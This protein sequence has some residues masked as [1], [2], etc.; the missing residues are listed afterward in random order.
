MW[1]YTNHLG[2]F[3][4]KVAFKKSESPVSVL[5]D[6]P[7][8]S[9]AKSLKVYLSVIRY[10]GIGTIYS[11][12]SV[13]FIAVACV[14]WQ[15]LLVVYIQCYFPLLGIKLC[16][17]F[18]VIRYEITIG[19]WELYRCYSLTQWQPLLRIKGLCLELK[20]Q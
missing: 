8:L 20:S 7:S 19:P 10:S 2:T 18:L 9:S 5:W 3:K 14:R 1:S 6:I 11:L 16:L 4:V 15:V 17:R 13:R 12:D